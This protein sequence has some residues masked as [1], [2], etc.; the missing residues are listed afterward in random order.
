M[1]LTGKQKAYERKRNSWNYYLT[2]V[3]GQTN[4]FKSHSF[5]SVEKL[6]P[7]ATLMEKVDEEYYNNFSGFKMKI[8]N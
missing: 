5:K 1:A 2:M 6:V 7:N 4:C 8:N 3:H